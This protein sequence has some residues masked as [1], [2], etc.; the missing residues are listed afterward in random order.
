MILNYNMQRKKF[1]FFFSK[2]KFVVSAISHI[3]Q[4]RT[5]TKNPSNSSL[6]TNVIEISILAKI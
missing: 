4:Y 3:S 5:L 2:I 1:D 6:R